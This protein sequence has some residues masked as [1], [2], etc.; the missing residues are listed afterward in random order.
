MPTYEEI[1]AELAKI[2][3]ILE[4]YPEA[5]RPQVY[6]LLIENYLGTS[7]KS[8]TITNR[9]NQ[10][11]EAQGER[12]KPKRQRAGSRESFSLLKNLDLQGGDGK[13]SFKQFCDEKKPGS[14]IQ[15]N[16]VAIYY[17]AKLL[18]LQEVT[19]NHIYTCYAEVH[20]QPPGAF[21]QSLY[22]TSS[23]KYGY[24]DANDINDIKIPHRGVVFVEHYLPAAA[25]TR[26]KTD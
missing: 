4:K 11:P 12:K 22:D 2:A 20:R 8:T 14:N 1:K 6:D 9:R 17:L 3:E 23:N 25:K 15:F 10:E 13:P 18:G 19:P 21:A 7:P 24:I 16:A 5:I 26:E